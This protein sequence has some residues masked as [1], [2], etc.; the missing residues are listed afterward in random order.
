MSVDAR[1]PAPLTRQDASRTHSYNTK[2]CIFSIKRRLDALL[3][4]PVN[5]HLC[6]QVGYWERSHCQMGGNRCKTT[7]RTYRAKLMLG[8]KINRALPLL[9]LTAAPYL[10]GDWATALSEVLSYTRNFGSRF[11]SEKG[12]WHAKYRT[13]Y[14]VIRGV[15]SM[16][17]LY[18]VNALCLT[19]FVDYAVFRAE[20]EKTTPGTTPSTLCTYG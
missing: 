5:R 3:S 12:K 2:T 1:L 13:W 19:K 7:T 8:V 4:R 10:V 14:F 6:F 18:S 16:I 11:R 9:L 17:Q 20:E 15:R